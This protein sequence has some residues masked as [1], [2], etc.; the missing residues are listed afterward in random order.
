MLAE[1]AVDDR[2]IRFAVDQ[3][4]R[5]P[6]A[7]ALASGDFPANAASDLWRHLVKPGWTVLDVGA[8]LGTY[9]LPAAAAGALVL[10]IEASPANAKLLELAVQ[11][12]S[13]E[14]IEIVN[15]AAVARAGT[16]AFKALGPWGHVLF[17]GESEEDQTVSSV[18]AVALDDVL[19]ERGRD[20]VDLVKIDV[21]GFELEALAG[22]ERLLG[23][24]DAP[25]LLIE[26]NGHMLNQYGSSPGDV[27]AALERH[28]YK[29]HQIDPGSERRLVPVRA[30]DLQPECVTDYLAF[31]VTPAGLDPWWVDAPF[32]RAELIRRVLAT[33]LDDN[34][35]QREYGARL[36]A[37]SPAW[38]LQDES[39]QAVRST[40]G[41]SR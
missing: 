27:L 36:L 10:A 29:C 5:D 41:D 22:L 23:R 39:V 1:V 33:C 13:F 30:T 32:D 37:V 14:N 40:L 24:E 16:V 15:A 12:N 17:E 6:I 20:H 2:V 8:H 38:L 9:S 7:D 11:R 35:S 34:S 25:P 21:E 28:E 19:A 4:S 3:S 31:K 18:A 26:A